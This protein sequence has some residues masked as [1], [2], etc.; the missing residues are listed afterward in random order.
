MV[1]VLNIQDV[2]SYVETHIGLFHQNRL[3]KLE[4]LK[5]NTVL[6]RKNPYLF[7]AKNILTSEQLVRNVLDAYLS[8]QEETLFGNFLEGVAIYVCG[9]VYDGRKPS[10]S[11]LEGI[12]LVFNNDNRIFIVE[13]KSGPK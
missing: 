6:L 12:D 7:K 4:G 10:T 9:I 1:G 2:F 11:A 5:L 13:I 3:E 8:S